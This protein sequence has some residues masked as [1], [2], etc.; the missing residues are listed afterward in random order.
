MGG[1]LFSIM[2][3][4][5]LFFAILGSLSASAYAETA[6]SLSAGTTGI[7]VHL[8][9]P[10]NDKLNFRLGL[11][12]Y[13]GS[14]T[15]KTTTAT[16]DIKAN[17]RTID[18]LVDFHPGAS[19]FRLSGGLVYNGNEFDATATPTGSGTYTFNGTAYPVASAGNVIGTMEFKKIAPYLGIGY[20]NAV[21][22]DKGWGFVAD[23][24]VMFQGSPKT[25]LQS[26]NCTAGTVV[27]DQLA[28][29]LAA[30]S[31]KLQ[32]EAKDYRFYPVVRVGLSYKF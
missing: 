28:A 1:G 30:E 8:I 7:G 25:N 27:C 18:A 24:G 10:Y 21:S 22:K 15:E 19:G 5:I 3:K 23:L 4:F 12:G 13:S 2:K 32:N 16:Y 26:T 17:L 11:N 6:V 29:D 14:T 31:A 9:K 20:G